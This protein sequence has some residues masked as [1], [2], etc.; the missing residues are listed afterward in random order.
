MNLDPMQFARRLAVV[1]L[2]VTACGANGAVAAA[3]AILG[4]D[5]AR[6]LLARTGFGPTEAEVRAYVGLTRKEAVD[7]L[8]AQAR[9][10]AVT[11]LP[12]AL[13]DASPLRLP[14]GPD[15]TP[16]ERQAF[17]REQVQEGLLLRGWWLQE[18]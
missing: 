12:A 6:H 3:D 8:F 5:D 15:A 2:L 11:A 13:L 16:E 4:Y 18:M 14:R 1:V 17:I 7:R 9:T 10:T